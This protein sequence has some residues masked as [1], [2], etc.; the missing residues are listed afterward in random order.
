MEYRI[1]PCR[2]HI[3]SDGFLVKILPMYGGLFYSK[4]KKAWFDGFLTHGASKGRN[5]EDV[6]HKLI[7]PGTSRDDLKGKTYADLLSSPLLPDERLYM[8]LKSKS[9]WLIGKQ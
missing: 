2:Y 6:T 7:R 1:V 4:T 5:L 8:D 3:D 9:F